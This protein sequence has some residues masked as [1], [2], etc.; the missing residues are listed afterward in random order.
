MLKTKCTDVEFIGEGSSSKVSDLGSETERNLGGNFTV[1]ANKPKNMNIQPPPVTSDHRSGKLAHEENDTVTRKSDNKPKVDETRAENSDPSMEKDIEMLLDRILDHS[2]RGSAVTSLSKKVDRVS[3]IGILL[4]LRPA[5]MPALVLEIVKHYPVNGTQLLDKSAAEIICAIVLLFQQV[6]LDHRV[7]LHFLSTNILTYLLPYL[8]QSTF[9]RH[10][11][12]LRVSL[13][14]LFATAASKVPLE[15]LERVLL[16]ISA[17]DES[18]F[19]TDN[20]DENALSLGNDLYDQA[21]SSLVIC[22]SEVGKTMALILLARLLTSPRLLRCLRTD[23]GRFHK[24]VSALTFVVSYMARSFSRISSEN[25]GT[26]VNRFWW[27]LASID[28]E[29]AKRLLRFTLDCIYRLAGDDRMCLALRICLPVELRGRL[30]STIFHND[31]EVDMW[32]DALWKRLN[33]NSA[34]MTPNQISS[35]SSPLKSLPGCGL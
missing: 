2:T 19:C 12:Q 13:L 28:F 11:E 17:T 20:E 3:Q 8:K 31:S 34:S 29:K 26:D 21:V 23:Q 33:F 25:Q 24:L 10:T 14:G 6:V 7:R 35:M 32:L 30:F 18:T 1:E 9:D 15:F 22:L 27:S 4:Y 5:I 16:Q